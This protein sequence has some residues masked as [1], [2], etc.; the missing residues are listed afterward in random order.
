MFK[1]L[2]SLL[3]VNFSLLILFAA[4]SFAAKAYPNPWIPGSHTDGDVHGTLAGGVNFV[5][6]S[7][8][9]GTIFI[10]NT[11]GELVRQID[12]SPGRNTANWDGKNKIYEY[13]ASGV[14]IWVA[15]SGGSVQ[16]GKIVVIR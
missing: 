6:L 12:W 8:A 1:K 7:D 14:Y 5:E 16:N 11:T 2:F 10:Y 13:V 3:I 4:I 9:G 15:K